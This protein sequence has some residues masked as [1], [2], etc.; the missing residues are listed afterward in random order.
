VHYGL[1]R[2]LGGLVDVISSPAWAT[3]SGL[4]L[5]AAA[6]EAR[7]D[8]TRQRGGLSVKGMMSSLRGMFSDLL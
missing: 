4:L 2:G 5:Y 6:A 7:E 8:R 3:A 1:P